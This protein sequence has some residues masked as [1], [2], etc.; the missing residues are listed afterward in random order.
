MVTQ[1]E[2]PTTFQLP[3]TRLELILM[4]GAIEDRVAYLDAEI[5]RLRRHAEEVPFSDISDNED[6]HRLM[7]AAYSNILRAVEQK[8]DVPFADEVDL[9]GAFS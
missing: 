2:G 4:K 8:L 3:V 7:R 1:T 5:A 9:V 6:S